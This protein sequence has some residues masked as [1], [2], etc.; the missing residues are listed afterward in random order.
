M[1]VSDEV[2]LRIASDTQALRAD[3]RRINQLAQQSADSVA[4]SYSRS[5]RAFQTSERAASAAARSYQR[6]AFVSRGMGNAIQNAGF[7]VGDFAVQVAG[8]QSPMRAFVQQGTQLISMFGPWG[9]VV[10]AAGA[11]LGALAMA[12]IDAGDNAA[13]ATRKFRTVTEALEELERRAVS[14]REKALSPVGQVLMQGA[15][16]VDRL[17]AELEEAVRRR[18]E[19]LR[20]LQPEVVHSGR[21]IV[22]VNPEMQ[23]QLDAAASEGRRR[24]MAAETDEIRGLNKQIAELQARIADLRTAELTNQFT[25][26]RDALD[27]TVR[28]WREYREQIELVDAAVDNHVEGA[29]EMAAAMKAAIT[30]ERD[31]A[32]ER[33][34]ATEVAEAEARAAKRVADQ[35]ERV[36]NIMAS[37]Q[38]QNSLTTGEASPATED[39]FDRERARL[40]ELNEARERAKTLLDRLKGAEQRHAE[41]LRE[42]QELYVS[43]AITLEEYVALQRAQT[44]EFDKVQE[45]ARRAAE[46]GLQRFAREAQDTEKLLDDLAVDGVRGLEDALVD[47][48]TGAKSAKEAFADMARSIIADMARMMIRQNITGPLAQGLSGAMGGGG[49]SGGGA[50]GFLGSLFSAWSPGWSTSGASQGSGLGS[51]FSGLFRA[52]GGDVRAGQMMAVGERG[53]ELFVPEVPGNIVRNGA[54]ASATVPGGARPGG[55]GTYYIDAR[56]ADEAGMARL[57]ATIRALDGSIE[58]RALTVV[59]ERMGRDGNKFA[60]ARR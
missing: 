50:V 45:A 58:K 5:S 47:L 24:A 23:A 55:G 31:A 42:I 59:Q 28:I 40:E 39:L 34:R 37:T 17:T 54:R 29:A 56:G 20:Q 13:S 25:A 7:Q 32:L 35:W 38:G 49:A 12:F 57:E 51:V 1:P 53:P 6:T 2:V 16:D 27:P 33:A 21:K 3:L 52:G 19:A 22:S 41:A 11:V 60:G 10:G 36:R 4:R 8:G 14:A 18:D 48:T 26:M 46:T 9:A 43:G 15:S 30:A 44:E